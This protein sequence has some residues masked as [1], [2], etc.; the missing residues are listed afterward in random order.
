MATLKKTPGAQTLL[1][2]DFTFD[3]SAADTMLNTSAVATAFSAASGTVYDIYTLPVGSRVVGGDLDVV[4]V[5]DDTGTSTITVGDS[6]SA[7]RY[8]GSTSLKSQ[9]RTALVPTGYISLGEAIRITVANQN[10]N[11]TVGK[12][13]IQTAF[14]IEG[15]VTENLKTT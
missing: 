11:A 8:L 9:A 10:G 5:S 14:I 13:K 2:A 4:A 15:R 12:V 6:A 1:V 7:T 3:I